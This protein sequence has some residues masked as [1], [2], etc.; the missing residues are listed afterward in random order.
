MIDQLV[1][2]GVED[3]I[4]IGVVDVTKIPLLIPGSQLAGLAGPFALLT[5]KTVTVAGNCGTSQVLVSLAI[6]PAIAAGTHGTHIDCVNEG[7]EDPVGDRYIIDAAEQAALAT[8]IAGYNQ[9]I[10]ARAAA[11][12]F[13]Y[14]D[15]N[16]I[17]TAA[18]DRGEIP[19]V[20]NVFS[21]TE[22]FGPLFSLDGIHP[23]AH[24]QVLIANALIELINEEYGTA[25][26][27]ISH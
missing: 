10:S 19:T 21:A 18:R 26:R 23:S 1:A 20:P 12:G 13:T 3:G 27:P 24:G 16:V 4:L 5:G 11:A 7:P 17:F 15:P 6:A 22:P 14:Y 25:M 2:G 8:A 9:H